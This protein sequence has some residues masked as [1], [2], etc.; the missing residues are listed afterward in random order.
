M[1]T[2]TGLNLSDPLSGY[3]CHRDHRPRFLFWRHPVIPGGKRFG[4]KVL[5]AIV[6]PLV[7]VNLEGMLIYVA[8]H[9]LSNSSLV[10]WE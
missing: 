3:A 5:L 10:S 4:G 6:S 2:P 9:F 7:R 8:V 1:L